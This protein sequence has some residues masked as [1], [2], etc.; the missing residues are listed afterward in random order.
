MKFQGWK[1]RLFGNL[2]LP[3][4]PHSRNSKRGWNLFSK[5]FGELKLFD[6]GKGSG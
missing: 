2:S 6:S 5:N 1:F 4:F 3:F